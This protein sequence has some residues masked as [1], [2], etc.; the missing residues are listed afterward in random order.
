MVHFMFLR[1]NEPNIAL[2]CVSGNLKF[3]ISRGE[4]PD[5]PLVW[6]LGL[7][8]HLSFPPKQKLLYRSLM[9]VCYQ[10]V[11]SK[12]F[13][14]S[15]SELSESCTIAELTNNLEPIVDKYNRAFWRSR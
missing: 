12:E 14:L 10:I 7:C 4:P 6:C 13:S 11:K 9:A 3:K 8:P 2:N 1:K 5:P 15:Y